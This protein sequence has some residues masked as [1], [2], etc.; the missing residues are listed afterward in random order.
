MQGQNQERWRELCARAAVEQDAEK[1]LEL[2]EE[3]IRLLQEKDD[4]LR[5]RNQGASRKTDKIPNGTTSGK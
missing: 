2:T 4:R 1:L 5:H 3:I